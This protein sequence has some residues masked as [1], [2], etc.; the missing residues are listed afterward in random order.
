M[1]LETYERDCMQAGYSVASRENLLQQ[2]NDMRKGRGPS[3]ACNAMVLRSGEFKRKLDA[4]EVDGGKVIVLR[5]LL[6]AK[7][8]ALVKAPAVE[9]NQAFAMVVLPLIVLAGGK[10]SEGSL[11]QSYVRAPSSTFV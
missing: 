6:P 10:L 4:G 11:P 1:E 7:L 9:T 8:R 5:S 2:P 3:D